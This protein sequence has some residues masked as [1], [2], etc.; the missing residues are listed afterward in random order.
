MN[1]NNK[2]TV[3]GKRIVSFLRTVAFLERKC[4]DLEGKINYTI[5]IYSQNLK[6]SKWEDVISNTDRGKN[7]SPE[8][9]F[10]S[11]PE[12]KSYSILMI[13]K[14]EYWLHWYARDIKVNEFSLGYEFEEGKSEYV[15][16]YPPDGIH[17]YTVYVIAMKTDT[18]LK[19]YKF[20]DSY[21]SIEK[22]YEELDKDNGILAIGKLKGTYAAH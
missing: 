8:L 17:E 18:Y 5:N 6:D 22:I 1:I 2:A 15:G 19:D 10:D 20:D 7:K 4:V 14:D 21:K 3:W 16:P 13:D 11:V 9:R 12:A